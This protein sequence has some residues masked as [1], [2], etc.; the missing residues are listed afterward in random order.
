[1]EGKSELL[2]VLL[3]ILSEEYR[4]KGMYKLG[5]EYG[6]GRNCDE[7]DG[8]KFARS[9]FMALN[10]RYAGLSYIDAIT[11][12]QVFYQTTYP[13]LVLTRTHYRKEF[14]SYTIDAPCREFFRGIFVWHENYEYLREIEERA[15]ISKQRAA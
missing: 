11:A 1:M 7:V 4:L 5:L 2:E 6:E 10:E 14:D 3:D 8:L 15:K 12:A 9:F 13:L